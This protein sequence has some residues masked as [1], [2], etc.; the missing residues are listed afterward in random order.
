MHVLAELITHE[1]K[2]KGKP[3][4]LTGLSHKE[5]LRD[6]PKEHLRGG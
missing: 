4:S 5:K 3:A 6:E 1:G 2:V